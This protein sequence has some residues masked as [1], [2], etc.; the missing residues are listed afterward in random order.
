MYKSSHSLFSFI[1]H[2]AL[3]ASIPIGIYES[4]TF[5]MKGKIIIEYF[6]KSILKSIHTNAFLSNNFK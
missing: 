2:K 5:R 4:K 1:I 3:N 6:T